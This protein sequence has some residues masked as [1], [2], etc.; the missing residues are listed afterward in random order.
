[1]VEKQVID[2][3]RNAPRLTT[4]AGF[5]ERTASGKGGAPDRREP[6]ADLSLLDFDLDCTVFASTHRRLW[7]AFDSHYFAS[8]PF[9]LEEECRIG[10]SLLSL[11]LRKWARS[12]APSKLYTLGTGTGCLARTL[13]TL[14]DGRIEA[15]CC[16]PT[17]ANRD[18][19]FA[20]RGSQH[21]HF[22]HGPFFDLTEDRYDTDPELRPFRDGFDVLL[23]DTTFQM[24]NRDRLRQLDFIAPRIKPGGLLVQV[25]KLAHHDVD[26]YL[27]RER[28]K[29]EL[30][31]PRFFT[32]SS[33]T[34]KQDEVLDTMQDLQV[35]MQATGAA[36]SAFFRYSVIT[37][38]S[39]NF[40]TIISSNAR[41][42]VVEFV[43]LM[44]KPAIPPAFCHHPLPIVLVDTDTDPVAS[45]LNWR[46]PNPM[47]AFEPRRP[48]VY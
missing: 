42:A 4:L 33:I 45:Q 39:G 44:L 2:E 37:W 41:A 32:P 19:F 27:D 21:A 47:L 18:A 23:E 26:I 46:S 6:D 10:S 20:N 25:E 7:G 29:D 8:I 30:F 31:K 40:Y 11:A 22:F 17:T 13:S 48:L 14:G 3:W 28:Q 15:L 5:F 1:M 34:D 12:G 36:L 38:N 16:S 9:R 35:D 24:Y 43:S